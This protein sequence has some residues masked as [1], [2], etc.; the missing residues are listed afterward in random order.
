MGGERGIFVDGENGP[1]YSGETFEV[2]DPV[3]GEVDTHVALGGPA[4]VKR[5]VDSGERAFRGAWGKADG[6][7]RE[8]ALYALAD[9][10]DRHA[11]ELAELESRDTGK[12]LH[13]VKAIDVAG[14]ARI[15][16][17][18][19]GWA[20]K[21]EGAVEH[22]TKALKFVS[23]EP[24]GVCAAILPWNFPLVLAA[25]KLGP[26][27]A[28]GNCIVLKPAEQAPL[29]M[30]RLAELATESGIPT[31]VINVVSGGPDTGRA[32]VDEPRISKISFTGSVAAGR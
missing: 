11:D 19:A 13:L 26:A 2:Y 14:T 5:A 9:L 32:L 8:R 29:P 23:H 22:Q 24:H 12:P 4:D 10:V 6:R 17:Y 15:I 7:E 25:W 3:T 16:R 1:S 30:L 21:L 27:L 18:F 20:T 31:G 28:A